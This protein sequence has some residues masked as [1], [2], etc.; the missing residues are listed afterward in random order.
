MPGQA[1]EPS[2]DQPA[3][4][5]QGRGAHIDPHRLAAVIGCPPGLPN[6]PVVHP[7]RGP[8]VDFHGHVI[9]QWWIAT[10]LITGETEA[11]E[12]PIVM[13]VGGRRYSGKGGGIGRVCEG[14]RIPS[15]KALAVA[16][17]EQ[18]AAVRRT[19]P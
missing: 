19:A 18:Y 11:D 12:Y 5:Q 17:A 3:I 14:H 1:G 16:E 8:L 10:Q 4:G 9:G 15:Q 13:D 7:D 6:P 2:G